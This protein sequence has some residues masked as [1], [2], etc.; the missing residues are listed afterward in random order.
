MPERS[1]NEDTTRS[2]RVSPQVSHQVSPW[3]SD[4]SALVRVVVDEAGF[5]IQLRAPT[6]GEATED[7]LER[8]VRR[9]VA[10]ELCV[11]EQHVTPR[12]RFMEDLGASSIDVVSLLIALEEKF[13]V[14]FPFQDVDKIKTLAGVVSLI[15]RLQA[16]G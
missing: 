4:A 11:K 13:R 8:Q 3:A 12:A 6:A 5:R 2:R 15:R 14:E 10:N 16:G 7:P 1:T 9:T